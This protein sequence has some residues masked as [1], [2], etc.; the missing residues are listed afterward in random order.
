LHCRLRETSTVCRCPI[1]EEV[2]GVWQ[3]AAAA[4][5]IHHNRL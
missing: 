3:T 2:H 4:I 5:I 1:I